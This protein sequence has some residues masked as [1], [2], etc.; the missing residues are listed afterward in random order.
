MPIV[1]V[2]IKKKNHMKEFGRRCLSDYKQNQKYYRWTIQIIDI[3]Y[4][5]IIDIYKIYVNSFYNKIHKRN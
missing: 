5:Q 4:I 1:Y 2:K 3:Y